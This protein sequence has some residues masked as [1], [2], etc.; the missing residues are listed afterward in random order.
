MKFDDKEEARNYVWDR[1]SEVGAH[2]FPFRPRRRIPNFSGADEAA[3]QLARHSLFQQAK[4]VKINPDSPQRSVREMALRRQ[5]TVVVPTPRL[6]E[7][8][9]LFHPSEIG[10]DH[11]RDASMI[12][13][14][15]RWANEIALDELPDV[16]AIVTGCVA[17]TPGG[18]RVGKGHGYSD[19]E[20]AILQ[21]LG[22]SKAPV[23]TTVH[24][25]QVVDDV[26]VGDHDIHLK[27]I[28]TPTRILSVDN[29]ED[30]PTG[31]DWELL[32]DEDL[33]AMPVLQTL[34]SRG[35]EDDGG[36]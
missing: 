33:E 3:R 9:L 21:Q 17:V 1:L 22:H 18:K 25:E 6:A 23:V 5:K 15:D 8:F 7:G 10:E 19:L 12:S 32:D 27:L 2:R 24:D 16:D 31:I 35:A 34:K 14:W 28:A 26:P 4:V 13:R 36:A 11:I 20:Y 30:G 29:A